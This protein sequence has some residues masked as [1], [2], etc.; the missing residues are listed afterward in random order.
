MTPSIPD[1][2]ARQAHVVR[3][4]ARATAL[5]VHN[6][7]FYNVVY[8]GERLRPT[9]T[10]AAELRRRLHALFNEDWRNVQDGIYPAALARD[11]SWRRL[12]A[13]Y[14]RMM[15]DAPRVRRRVHQNIYDDVPADAAHF[16]PYYRRNFHFQTDGYFGRESAALYEQQVE[17][18]FGGTANAMRRQVLPP[19]VRELRGREPDS[20]KLLDLACG[21]GPVLRMLA[22]ALPGARLFGCDLSPQYIAHARAALADIVPLSLVAENAEHLP[23]VTGYFDA[24][25]CVYLFHELPPAVRTQVLKEAARVLAPGALLVIADSLQ[26]QDAPPLKRHL[27]HFPDQFHEPFYPH[28]LRD[29]LAARLDGAGFDLLERH[30]HFVTLVLVARRRTSASA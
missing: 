22:A 16:P 4:L 9:A 14:P 29:D 23:F 3:G 18:V 13:S 24:A 11:F 15:L 27:E 10:E 8:P 26:L 28:Y 7:T 19:L 6:A 12:L 2:I 17:I 25:T 5:A 20:L 21:T 30:T 1:E